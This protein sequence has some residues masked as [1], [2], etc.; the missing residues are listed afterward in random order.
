MR[1]MV[2]PPHLRSH[3]LWGIVS[4][5]CT[6]GRARPEPSRYFPQAIELDEVTRLIE[7]DQLAHL[8]EHRRFRDGTAVR[9]DAFPRS[10]IDWVKLLPASMASLFIKW[11]DAA[12]LL[13]GT[14]SSAATLNPADP[15]HSAIGDHQC[16]DCRARGAPR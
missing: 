2:R 6:A 3:G 8:A 1:C 11:R 5:R 16:A 9:Q 10:Q 12:R 14:A 4:P 15:P 7:A 13:T